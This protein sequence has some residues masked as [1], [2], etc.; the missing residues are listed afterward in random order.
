MTT[1]IKNISINQN[2]LVISYEDNKPIKNKFN[3]AP[4]SIFMDTYGYWAFLGPGFRHY[5]IIVEQ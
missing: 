1:Q 4:N 5:H 3:L 2:N